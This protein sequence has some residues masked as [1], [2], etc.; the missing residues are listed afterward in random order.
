M[1]PEFIVVIPARYASTRLPGKPLEE[2][3]GKP[4]V[5][6]AYEAARGSRAS[7]VIIATDDNRIQQACAAFCKEVELTSSTVAS[8]TDRIAEVVRRRRIPEDR[9]VVNVQGDEYALPPTLIDQVADLLAADPTAVMATLCEPIRREADWRDSDIVKVVVTADGHA[10]YF[11]RAPIPW[12]EPGP[13]SGCTFRHIGLYAYRTGF[14]LEYAGLAPPGL[15]TAER[16]EQVRALHHGYRIR[17][18]IAC[19]EA[20]IGIDSRKDLDQARMQETRRS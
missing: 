9:I 12:A 7:L 2:I 15:E 20:G 3:G 18:A 19:A 17:V 5:Q 8:G 13:A 14:L 4:L 6:H 16:L 11:S 1:K 10:L